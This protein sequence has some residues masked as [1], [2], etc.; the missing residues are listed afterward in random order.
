MNWLPIVQSEK[1]CALFCSLPLVLLLN[2]WLIFAQNERTSQRISFQIEHSFD[3]NNEWK[4]KGIFSFKNPQSFLLSDLSK[5]QNSVKFQHHPFTTED[6]VKFEKAIE[7]N[8]FYKVRLA[9]GSPHLP[10]VVSAVKA[11]A[12]LSSNFD[13]RIVLH[14]DNKYNVIG[15]DY[16]SG[17]GTCLQNITHKI[18]DKKIEFKTIA[19]LQ[20]AAEAPKPLV[21]E[22]KQQSQEQDKKNEPNF[23]AKYWY[24][25]VPI[26]LIILTSALISPAPSETDSDQAASRSSTHNSNRPGKKRT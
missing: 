14:L 16:S 5:I 17:N 2:A 7:A 13:E 8:A 4:P 6:K 15:I 23:F 1:L 10:F 20:F 3:N 19:E 12:L 11:C 26:V 21:D 25:I 24:Y 22:V 18:R 9:T